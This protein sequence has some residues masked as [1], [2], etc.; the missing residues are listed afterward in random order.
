MVRKRKATGESSFRSPGGSVYQAD[1]SSQPKQRPIT[2]PPPEAR[3]G[4][5]GLSCVTAADTKG[6]GDIWVR[7]LNPIYQRDQ[8]CRV[9]LSCT[10]SLPVSYLG[11]FTVTLFL[12]IAE[13]TQNPN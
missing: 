10:C 3:W 5:A 8:H 4:K 9:V 12:N 1:T 13:V 6:H 7:S 11:G 2:Y